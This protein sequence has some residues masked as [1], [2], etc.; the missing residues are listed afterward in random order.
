[1]DKYTVRFDMK[2]PQ[3]SFDATTALPYY[4]IFAKE[5]FDKQ[6]QFIKQPIG[7]GAFM[8]KESIYQDHATAVRNPNF[9][10]KPVWMA[11]KYKTTAMPLMD[12]IT[13]QYFPTIPATPAAFIAG[14][15]DDY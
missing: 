7:T 15:V 4:G 6:D 8:N 2:Q 5:H 9:S 1:P 11:D 3:V 12:Q 13:F 14:Q 10:Q